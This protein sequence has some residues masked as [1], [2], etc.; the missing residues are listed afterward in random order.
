MAVQERST[1]VGHLGAPAGSQALGGAEPVPCTG[2]SQHGWT[3]EDSLGGS[4]ALAPG[5]PCPLCPAGSRRASSTEQ[6]PRGIGGSVSMGAVRTLPPS[7]RRKRPNGLLLILSSLCFSCL[8]LGPR[9]LETNRLSMW[10]ES[11]KS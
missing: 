6:A 5:L 4:S 7:S 10:K 11:P 3:S 1:S 9:A 8:L 2:L